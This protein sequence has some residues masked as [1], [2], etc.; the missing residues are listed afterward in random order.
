MDFLKILLIVIQVFTAFSVI[1]LVLLQHGKG[2]DMGAAFGSGS[3]GSFFGASGSASFLS[4]MTGMLAAIFFAVTLAL[5]FLNSYHSKTSLGVLGDIPLEVKK[6][7][8]SEVAEDILPEVPSSMF[9]E[10][11]PK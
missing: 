3:S 1:G 10:D 8:T 4:R 11:V 7:M 2:A 6:V 9:S 5:T